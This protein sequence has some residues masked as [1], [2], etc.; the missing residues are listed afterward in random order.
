MHS[1]KGGND[2]QKNRKIERKNRKQSK[3]REKERKNIGNQKEM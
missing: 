2:K 1:E 3:Q